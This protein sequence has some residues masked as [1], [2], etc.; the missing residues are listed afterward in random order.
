MGRKMKKKLRKDK[1]VRNEKVFEYKKKHGT[2]ERMQEWTEEKYS[3]I[4]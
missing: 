4:L 1:Q 2:E 3:Y